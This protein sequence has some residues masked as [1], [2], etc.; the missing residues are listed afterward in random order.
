M[1]E[2]FGERFFARAITQKLSE[3]FFS[4]GLE[5]SGHGTIKAAIALRDEDLRPDLCKIAVPTAIF[6]GRQD[7]I[8]PFPLAEALHAGIK[9]S[10]LVP[11]EYSGHGLFYCEGERFNRELARFIG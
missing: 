5:A 10:L 9:G 11:F 1:L 2:G 7:R 8:A 3:W 6:H 4:L